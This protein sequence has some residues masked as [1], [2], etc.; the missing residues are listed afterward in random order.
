M[1]SQNQ[2]TAELLAWAANHH[3]DLWV[4]RFCVYF[5]VEFGGNEALAEILMKSARGDPEYRVRKQVLDI[6]LNRFKKLFF[7]SV[8][9]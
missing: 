1:P 4:R 7:G 9:N 6:Q 2:E 5:V 3:P 8:E